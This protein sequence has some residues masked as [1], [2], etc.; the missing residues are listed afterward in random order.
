M[1][2][3]V[4]ASLLLADE[5]EQLRATVE[6]FAHKEVAPIIGDLYEREEFPYGIVAKM[7]AMGLFGLPFPRNTEAW[8]V[9]IWRSAWL[10]RSSHASTHRWP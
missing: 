5:H 4:G 2:T 3:G 7:G 10:S 8:A 6:R 9:T 1:S